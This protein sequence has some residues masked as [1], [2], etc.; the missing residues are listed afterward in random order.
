MKSLVIYYSRSGTTKK[1]AERIST[2]LG[3]EIEE[4]HDLTKR[5]GIV[6]WLKAGRDASSRRLTTLEPM[7]ND[8]AA[9][10][11]VVVGTPV[12]AHTMSTPMRSYILK[13]KEGFNKVAFFCTYTLRNDNPF[14]EMESLCGK[15]PVATLRLLMKQEVESDQYAEKTEEFVTKIKT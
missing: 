3:G 7:K 11:I 10:D 15:K 6:G 9:Y 1:V 8:P 13:Y 4:I 12:W 5:S 14:D 2:L